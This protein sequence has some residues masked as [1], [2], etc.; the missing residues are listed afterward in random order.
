V[1]L[2][3]IWVHGPYQFHLAKKQVKVSRTCRSQDPCGTPCSPD[4]ETLGAVPVSIPA[5]DLH[6]P[7]AEPW[8]GPSSVEA[9]WSFKLAEV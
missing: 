2:L 5:P 9:I 1:K 3:W 8:I 4:G 6:R 7:S